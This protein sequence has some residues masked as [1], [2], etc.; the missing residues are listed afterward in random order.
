MEVLADWPG[1]RFGGMGDMNTSVSEFIEVFILDVF[2]LKALLSLLRKLCSSVTADK[3]TSVGLVLESTERGAPNAFFLTEEKIPRALPHPGVA[4]G[5]VFPP[6]PLGGV[7]DI[8]LLGCAKLI[9]RTARE[10]NTVETTDA[11][12]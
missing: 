8:V 7:D 10:N 6:L 9:G 3:S 1:E 4:A 2:G 11:I 12:A 5:G